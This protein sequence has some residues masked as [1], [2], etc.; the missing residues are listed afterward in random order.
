MGDA[1]ITALYETLVAKWNARD[2]AGFADLFTDDGSTVGFDGS[3]VDGRTAIRDHLASIFAGHP[4]ASFIGIVR[5]VRGLTADVAL[6]RVVVGMVPPGANDINPAVNA[7]QSLVAVR[8][9]GAW[10]LALFQNTPAAFH[11]RPADV[12]A[13]SAELRAELKRR[14]V[15]T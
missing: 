12:E 10:R 7:V 8:D 4:T 15:S 11:G 2:A 6:L 14:S 13:L 5:E 9:S 3:Q 1:D